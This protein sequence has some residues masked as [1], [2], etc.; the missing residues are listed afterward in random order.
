MGCSTF[1]IPLVPSINRSLEPLRT[2]PKPLFCPSF[3]IPTS[4]VIDAKLIAGGLLFGG[5]WGL[6]GICPGPALVAAVTG[7]VHVLSFLGAMLGG[8]WLESHLVHF[9][10]RQET[11]WL[12]ASSTN[13]FKI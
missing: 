13:G 8:M 9:L 5:G 10:H 4:N 7:D 2:L 3:Q 12:Y 1:I 11:R 6:A